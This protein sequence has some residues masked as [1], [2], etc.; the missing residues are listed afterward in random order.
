MRAKHGEFSSLCIIF[1][2]IMMF[3][4][5]CSSIRNG[6]WS[7]EAGVTIRNKCNLSGPLFGPFVRDHE[8]LD[9]LPNTKWSV[10]DGMNIGHSW[11]AFPCKNYIKLRLALLR[12]RCPRIQPTNGWGSV[13][14]F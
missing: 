8:A 6:R 9:T 3:K 4:R 2:Q 10:D 7:P 14:L 11:C 12:L 13:T 5:S 1:S